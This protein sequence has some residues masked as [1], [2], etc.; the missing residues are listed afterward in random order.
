MIHFFFG[1]VAS[2]LGS[3]PFGTVNVSVI[4]TTVR[5][6]FKAGLQIAIAAGLVEMIQSFIAVHCSMFITQYIQDSLY[7][8]FFIIFLLLAIGFY[9]FTRKGIAD[10]KAGGKKGFKVSDFTKGAILGLINPQ[11]LPFYVFVITWLQAQSLI[12]IHQDAFNILFFL[13]GTSAGRFLALF[14][15]GYLS[16]KLSQKLLAVSSTMNKVL[17]GLFFFLALVQVIQIL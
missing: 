12:Q 15:Y 14:L 2:F 5:K 8:K 1:L 6:S 7:V 3:I 16:S 4:D 11:A 9:F 10:T 13:L 17:G